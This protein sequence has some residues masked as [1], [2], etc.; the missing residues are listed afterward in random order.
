MTPLMSEKDFKHKNWLLT[1]QI[2]TR[3]RNFK[4]YWSSYFKFSHCKAS[5]ECSSNSLKI[6][7]A[8]LRLTELSKIYTYSI[9]E[10]GFQTCK[11]AALF[12]IIRVEGPFTIHVVSPYSCTKI[13]CYLPSLC[14]NQFTSSAQRNTLT[15]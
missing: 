9:F 10:T 15:R 5:E 14:I 7:P 4:I 13:F 3:K 2:Y 12:T 8:W 6:I 11:L 1:I